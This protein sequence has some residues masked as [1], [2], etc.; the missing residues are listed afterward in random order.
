MSTT[1]QP[2]SVP[3][4]AYVE[5]ALRKKTFGVLTTLDGK[6]R[7]HSTG[8]LY[9]VSPPGSPFA[10]FFLTLERYLKVRNVRANP[11]GT[12]VVP[13]PHRILSFIP[14]PCVTIRG[15]AEVV[16]FSD[17][18]ARWG[19]EQRRILRDNVAWLTDA[20]PVFLKLTP[21]PTVLCHG[22]GIG[23]FEMRRK[24]TAGGYKAHIP[25]ERL[26]G[27]AAGTA[28]ADGSTREANT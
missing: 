14:A 16:P 12:L 22:V 20:E 7:P 23:L 27:T 8:I 3:T 13:F 17:P 9:G 18:D 6:G 11:P 26:V 28:D 2:S 19:F 1:S 10:F 5:A 24:H 21:E 4:F 15:R 25:V